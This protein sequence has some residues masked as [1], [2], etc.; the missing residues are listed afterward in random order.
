MTRLGLI[1]AALLA[2]LPLAG[3]ANAQV[4][5]PWL[6]G[7]GGRGS[8]FRTGNLEVHPG[9]AAEAGYDS[10]YFQG[11]GAP[12][13]P[14]VPTYRL[15]LTPSLSLETLG[16]Q[17][18]ADDSDEAAAPGVR[19]GAGASLTLDKLLAAESNDVVEDGV[20][21]SGRVAGA[22]EVQP[23]RPM[24]ADFTLGYTRISQPYNSPGALTYN[25]SVIDGGGDLRW[26]P[27][28][29][30]LQWSLG[31]G[32]GVTR[33]DEQDFALDRATHHLRTRGSWR[34][35][36]RTALLYF[37]DVQFVNRLDPESRLPNANPVSTQ[38]GLNGLIT[39]RFSILMLGGFKAIFFDPDAA[40]NVEEFDD[41]IGRAE[42]TWFLKGDAKFDADRGARGLAAIRVGY[43]RD[44]SISDLSNYFLSNRVYGR[45]FT[46]VGSSVLLT[47]SG[48]LTHVQHA[49][50]RNEEG[51]LLAFPAPKEWRPD[52]QLYAEYRI[53]E[54]LAAFANAGYSASTNNNVV[55]TGVGG[56]QDSLKYSRFTGLI[57]ARWFK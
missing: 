41:I 24:G 8:G 55:S 18:T 12:L 40:G 3:I 50:P 54:S 37:G 51:D 39:E 36:P 22:L 49:L 38:F 5:Q 35:L 6:D 25:R 26:R 10:N 42:L 48:G 44:G 43:Q 34:F 9:V 2:V 33:Y 4:A 29:G 20:L 56:G 57:G 27:G 28:G 47:L 45:I 11:A 31:Y 53:T 52:A 17:R 13:E 16:A 30:L 1:V 15:R 46:N 32:V 7:A 21:L 23:E 19:F 14:E